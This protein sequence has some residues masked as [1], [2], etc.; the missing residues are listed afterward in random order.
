VSFWN[1]GQGVRQ[2]AGRNGIDAVDVT[3]VRL[4]L[5]KSGGKGG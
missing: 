2:H 5:A 4:F 3:V 1:P